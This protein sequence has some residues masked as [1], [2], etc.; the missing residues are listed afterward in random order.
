[1]PRSPIALVPGAVLLLLAPVPAPAAG[2]AAD[3][4]ADTVVAYV[5]GS[6]AGAFTDPEAALGAPARDSGA[7]IDPGVV[8][9]FQPAWMPTELVSVGPGGSLVV[10]FDEPVTDDPANPFGIDLLIFGNAFFID[11]DA[12]SGLVAGLAAEG[13]AIEV[14]LDGVAWTAVPGVAAEGLFPTRGWIDAGPYDDAPGAVPTDFT[15]PID[16]ALA[17]QDVMSLDWEGL[18]LLYGA[19]GG[20]T[21]IDLAPLGLEAIRFV[22]FTPDGASA[23]EID[24]LAD[25]RPVLAGDVDGDGAVDFADLLA[26]LAAWGDCPPPCPSDLDGDGTTGFADLLLV[27]AGW[28]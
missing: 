19:S 21:G 24:G 8:S 18:T 27:L 15:L 4:W 28:S 26:L 6:G 10:A 2:G 14:S 3:P 25:V 1:M 9:P 11:G 7:G 23:F 13:G 12:P 20:G 22:R 16:P 17:L 5:P